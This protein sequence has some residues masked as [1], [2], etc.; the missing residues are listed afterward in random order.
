MWILIKREILPVFAPLFN[1]SLGL[2]KEKPFKLG[3]AFV[4]IIH[5]V[6]S[7]EYTAQQV[8]SFVVY[9][10]QKDF[11]CLFSLPKFF[12]GFRCDNLCRD[13]G[14]IFDKGL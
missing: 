8:P 13:A 10:I 1:Q 4:S 9:F 12:F 3:T 2:M 6:G 11:G 5:P 7:C 14:G